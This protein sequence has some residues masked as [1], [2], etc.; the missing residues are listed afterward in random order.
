MPAMHGSGAPDARMTR[1]GPHVAE[2]TDRAAQQPA[3]PYRGQSV[4]LL[5]RHG[6]DAV[7]APV[8]D[9]A[10]GCRVVHVDGYDTD[11]L[12]TFTRDIPRAGTQL[13]AA[14]TKARLGMQLSG[15]T[16]GLGS[17][18]AFGS[19]PMTG[20]V[21]WNVEMVAWVDDRA[22]IEVVG[23]AHGAAMFAHLLTPDLTNARA[24]AAQWGFPGHGIVMRPAHRDD[25]RIHRDVTSWDALDAGFMRMRAQ[26]SNGLVF[27]ETD[28]RAH[29]NPTRMD[30]IRRATVDLAARLGARCPACAAPGFWRVERVPGLP[31]AD[32]GAPTGDPRAD[33]IGCV[34]CPHRETRACAEPAAAD[35]SRCDHCNP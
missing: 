35:P 32:C 16:V 34:R 29:A 11:R 33:V 10:T 27:L 2:R 14:R 22:G 31:C 23:T 8:L 30:M 4:A 20:L 3:L 7:I 18:G 12:G 6:K 19:D 1:T 17:E 9:A 26:A 5:T 15:M 28:L 25:A 13:D 24:F 21:P